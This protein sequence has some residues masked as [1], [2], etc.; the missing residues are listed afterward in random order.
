[1]LSVSRQ[2]VK[3][4]EVHRFYGIQ[5]IH[6]NP[7]V[8]NGFGLRTAWAWILTRGL[9]N[10]LTMIGSLKSP[11]GFLRKLGFVEGLNVYA[12]TGGNPVSNSDPSGL[13]CASAGGTTT[14]S[15]PNGTTFSLPTPPDF[16]ASIGPDNLFY[17]DYDVSRSLGCADPDSVFQGLANSPTPGTASPATPNGTPNNAVVPFLPFNNPVTSYL[18]NDVNTGMLL[19]VN[20]TGPGSLFGPGYVARYVQNGVVHTIGEG[21]NAIQSPLVIGPLVQY[22]ADEGLWGSQMSSIIGSAKSSCG[23]SH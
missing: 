1:M 10:F 8:L 12:Y 13:L 23:C 20:I 22:A 4:A 9:W 3:R 5:Q 16:P 21:L 17:H 15:N 18:T 14:C 7:H 19:V 11:I 2:F 6:V